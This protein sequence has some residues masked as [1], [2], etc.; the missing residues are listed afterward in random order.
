MV[1]LGVYKTSQFHLAACGIWNQFSFNSW[2]IKICLYLQSSLEQTF[3][4]HEIHFVTNS[5]FQACNHF[6]HVW[7]SFFS[8][9]ILFSYSRPTLFTYIIFYEMEPTKV[10]YRKWWSY[11]PY[12][13]ILTMFTH[14]GTRRL[15]RQH[16]SGDGKM[17]LCRQH[18]SGDKNYGDGSYFWKCPL[19]AKVHYLY[20]RDM[21]K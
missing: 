16:S 4:K 21:V 3:R 2:N 17:R 12:K 10:L 19:V 20:T 14:L 5:V 8:Q 13:T 7:A 11:H 6:Y 18:I 1:L 9:L 15:W